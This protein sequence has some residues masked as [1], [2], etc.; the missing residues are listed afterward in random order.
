MWSKYVVLTAAF[1]VLS[2]VIREKQHFF[3]HVQRM[4]ADFMES[5]DRRSHYYYQDEIGERTAI[6]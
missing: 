1:T 4:W 2:L 5:E 3:L 6:Q